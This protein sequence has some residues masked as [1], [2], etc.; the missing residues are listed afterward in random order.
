VSSDYDKVSS[1]FE[2]LQSYLIRLKVLEG[3]VPPSPEL[4]SIVTEI[5]A[6]VLVLLGF[7]TKYIQTKRIGK[8]TSSTLKSYSSE[9]PTNRGNQYQ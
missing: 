4:V 8:D 6:S 3:K 9:P 1:L 7:F 5:L 2:E